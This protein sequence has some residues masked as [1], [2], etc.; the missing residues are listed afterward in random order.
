MEEAARLALQQAL[1]EFRYD[2]LDLVLVDDKPGIEGD[3]AEFLA[4]G[5]DAVVRIR[6]IRRDGVWVAEL[7]G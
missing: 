2:H 5:A 7:I 6:V 4:S 1:P 3:R